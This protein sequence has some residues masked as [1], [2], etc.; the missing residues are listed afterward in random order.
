[1]YVLD[2]ICFQNNIL[3]SKGSFLF[4]LLFVIVPLIVATIY[5]FFNTLTFTGYLRYTIVSPY[6]LAQVLLLV[7][8]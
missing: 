1:M 7:D 6:N 8:R 2:Y 4:L 5:C 3:V